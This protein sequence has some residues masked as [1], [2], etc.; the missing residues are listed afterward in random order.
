MKIVIFN[1]YLHTRGG[2]EK[3]TL[4]FAG[5]CALRYKGSDITITSWNDLTIDLK[6]YAAY[7][8]LKVPKNIK[9]KSILR[10]IP[11]WFR[12]L[13]KTR[14]FKLLFQ[15]YLLR[16]QFSDCDL[17]INH[18]AASL[19]GGIG[20]R[21]IY[22][23]MFPFIGS[24]KNFVKNIVGILWTRLILKKYDLIAANSNFTR[25]LAEKMYGIKG[26]IRTIYPC[27][28]QIPVRNTHKRKGSLKILS[29][30][31][32]S[33]RGHRKRQDL[34]LLAFQSILKKIPNAQLKMIGSL[35]GKN[36]EDL[37]FFKNL[38]NTSKTLSLPVTFIANAEIEEKIKAL[39]WA[40]VFWLGTGFF[41]TSPPREI[42]KEHFGIVV[43]EAM[44]FGLI[45]FTYAGGGV[46]ELYEDGV[47]GFS[48]QSV[49]E[50]SQKT[51]GF[52]KK[53]AVQRKH[54]QKEAMHRVGRFSKAAFYRSL[55]QVM[56]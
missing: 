45:P 55:D 9:F 13:A 36:S 48:C 18:T 5:Y 46:V 41:D 54:M 26:K 16:K 8:G 4:D 15:G 27:F 47:S 22:V 24:S 21:N 39:Q 29:V 30:A 38:K 42:E 43:L 53:T 28:E 34:L 25:E 19:C 49:S 10:G 23:M 17:F 14:I 12:R 40:D 31:R 51:L 37:Q 52:A 50:L 1:N 3:S 11:S 33:D 32:F 56:I 35:D 44:Q 20:K 6:S 7:F 2:G